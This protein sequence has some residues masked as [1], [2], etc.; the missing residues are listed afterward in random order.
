MQKQQDLCY[1]IAKILFV[2]LLE[3]GSCFQALQQDKYEYVI[4]F[5][6]KYIQKSRGSFLLRVL[7]LFL[8]K[9]K[10]SLRVFAEIHCSLYC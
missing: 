1:E 3:F 10:I 4:E 6:E 5:S 8:V 7:T 9:N 2:A